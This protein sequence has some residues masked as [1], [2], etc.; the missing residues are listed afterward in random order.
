MHNNNNINNEKQTNK[1]GGEAG[2][3][4]WAGRGSWDGGQKEDVGLVGLAKGWALGRC[5]AGWVRPKG[6]PHWSSGLREPQV[7]LVRT[8]SA[9]QAEGIEL[10]FFC[11][12][13][14][15]LLFLL[16]RAL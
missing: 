5:R 6:E 12:F 4:K 13:F 3:V 10:E 16:S 8:W 15:P 7:E 9:C 2:L 11:F 1:L 14:L